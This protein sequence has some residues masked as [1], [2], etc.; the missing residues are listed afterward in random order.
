MI[1]I[2]ETYLN[3]LVNLSGNNRSLLLL[4]TTK[5]QD[6]D[7][8]D[9]DFAFNEPSFNIIKSFIEE[10]KNIPLC[11]S[12][13]HSDAKTNEASKRLKNIQRRNSFLF[14]ERGA[15]DLY[16]GWPFVTGKFMDGTSV[17]C[18]LLFFPI[19]IAVDSKN[20]WVIKRKKDV[21]SSFNKNFLLAYS[22]YN[23]VN[24][25][26][27]IAN[28]SLDDIEKDITIFRT[29]LYQL[30]KNSSLELH[31]NQDIFND[32]IEPYKNY[33]KEDYEALHDNGK[34]KL[35]Q[36]AVI[37]IFPQNS[38]YLFPDYK[39]L[40]KENKFESVE[41]LFKQKRLE[42][43]QYKEDLVVKENSLYNAFSMDSSQENVLKEVKKGKSLV[44]QGPPGTGK[45]QLICN[46]VS[47]YISRGKKVLVVCQKRAAL[48]VVSKRLA[49][50]N[51]RNFVG[52]VHDYKADRKALYEQ[53]SKQISSVEDYQNRNNGLDTVV[54]E[55]TFQLNSNAIIQISEEFDE[56]KEA[57]FDTHE[58]GLSVKELY[59]TSNPN[60]PFID[61][62]NNYH[63]L[64]YPGVNNFI[65]KIKN[66]LL[67]SEKFENHNYVLKNRK[68]FAEFES[69]D[70]LTFEKLIPE[71]ISFHSLLMAN[72]GDLLVEP[73]NLEECLWVDDKKDI[74]DDFLNDIYNE[75]VYEAF[76]LYVPHKVEFSRFNQIADSIYECYND[77]E[78]EVTL[79]SD[80]LGKFA[81]V[82]E[83][84]ISAKSNVFKWATFYFSKEK[85]ILKKA[86]INNGLDFKKSSLKKLE[87]ML[88]NRLNLEHNFSK[89]EAIGWIP[90]LP[91][92][93][94]I[95][96]IKS[97][98]IL[99]KKG[100]IAREKYQKLRSFKDFF[101]FK[102]LTLSDFQ[103]KTKKLF[104]II[105]NAK[106]HYSIWQKTY[107]L[108]QINKII[109]DQSF[110]KEFIS[111]IK[112]DFESLVEFDKILLSFEDYELNI[113]ND[114]T[115]KAGHKED[116][117]I[118]L[119]DNSLKLIWINHIE[120][121]YPVLRK[122]STKRF[123]QLE[124]ELQNNIEE[125]LEISNEI[126]QL[127]AREIT[128]KQ[129][130]YNRLRN[131]VTYRKLEKQVNKKRKIWPLRKLVN[132]CNEEL[133][134]IIPCW[135][136]SPETASS[137]FPLEE[138]FDLVIFDE[139]S[140]CYAE[141]ALPAIIRGKQVVIVGD[142]KQL[143]PNDL[144]KVRWDNENE[145]DDIDLDV[146]SILDLASLYLPQSN[147]N[148]HYRSQ[149][150]ELM[151]FSNRKFY[152]SS[153]KI[154]PSFDVIQSKERPIEYI[155]VDGIWE[156]NQN[157]IEAEKV[158]E[159]ITTLNK[160]KV[161]NIGVV[162]FNQKQQD[163]ISDLI[164]EK[165]SRNEI[166][167]G[168]DFFVKNIE[169]VQGDER[170]IIIF[171][172]GYAPTKNGR[173]NIQFGSLNSYKG[174]NRLNV[175]ISRA[176]NKI[177]VI[178]SIYPEQLKV[179]NTKNEGPKLFKEYLSYS[180]SVSEDKYKPEIYSSEKSSIAKSLSGIIENESNNHI[181]ELPF[182][183]ITVKKEGNYDSIILTDDNNYYLDLSAKET[184]CYTPLLFKDK[185][186][187]Y[188]R[189]YSR[190]WW[191][192]KV[193]LNFS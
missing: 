189:I 134:D 161:K 133:F 159:L 72:T 166:K 22:Y 171:S 186:W 88:D 10:S 46:L 175:A 5:S 123:D 18:P 174:E 130:E 64:V 162:T 24:F 59:L 139:A 118:K 140:Q 184:H 100:I 27:E 156:K 28:I 67:Y 103:E 116:D 2:L 152:N 73:I 38:S 170:D 154:L 122:V 45:S 98:L 85:Y 6:L 168:D 142:E 82:L 23:N 177:F 61:L 20:Q 113:L 149:S 77:E 143:I 62:K 50:K 153:L 33:K 187:K 54:L 96:T 129:L 150:L 37:G 160:E 8:H 81:G 91:V 39:Q 151:D 43:G 121:K 94:N 132:E 141:N 131:P 148:H 167:I 125:K 40:I 144:Y 180:L 164:D 190:Q 145:E 110:T 193:D 112:D 102:N 41:D 25:D 44:V 42:L 176:R 126:L 57:L 15:Q 169:N 120:E 9:L 181:Q 63:Y 165:I 58:C 13:D 51:I 147:L 95:E 173:L 92:D 136:T 34:L 3:R 89:L 163:L 105:E 179:E 191:E 178:S 93:R 188:K 70:L 47:D 68:S 60:G 127:K 29:E 182:A 117:I 90:E 32:K 80:E 135:L 172:I 36:N 52:L 137:I 26:E 106:S 138:V 99:Q 35:E 16:L 65:S 31:F 74:F 53:I 109:K 11:K 107:N 4:K 48:D 30:L 21:L 49:E 119:L 86:I 155:K 158:V 19:E 84:A 128:Y 66:Y 76:K 124:K 75:K 56:F 7:L 12:I 1:K 183:D 69:K 146:E 55:R 111:A 17:R 97:W 71:I 87:R 115:N 192:N 14:E 78:L 114:L 108:F 104:E 79:K 83:K 185:K 157:H 101:S